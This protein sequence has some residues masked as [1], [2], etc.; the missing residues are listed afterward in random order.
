MR[1]SREQ[2]IMIHSSDRCKSSKEQRAVETRILNPPF[3]GYEDE[4][5]QNNNTKE[6][7]A[8]HRRDNNLDG[9]ES[10]SA[11][12]GVNTSKTAIGSSLVS[13]ESEEDDNCVKVSNSSDSEE[14]ALDYRLESCNKKILAVNTVKDSNVEVS[15]NNLVVS[16]QQDFEISSYES[17]RSK[18]EGCECANLCSISDKLACKKEESNIKYFPGGIV[19]LKE[20][21]D[22]DF[23]ASAKERHRIKDVIDEINNEINDC[24]SSNFKSCKDV[25]GNCIVSGNSTMGE[26]C[27]CARMMV[28]D[29]AMA[30][31]IDEIT[32]C[33]QGAA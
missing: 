27:L 31:E 5:S 21:I 2:P 30:E 28:D 25:I 16:L 1:C 7:Y 12:D 14:C 4:D 13:R 3:N 19:K 20:T 17:I 9:P 22:F 18:C 26:G 11:N 32:P 24:N 10:V 6:S 8:V 15:T 23:H 33:P 29:Q